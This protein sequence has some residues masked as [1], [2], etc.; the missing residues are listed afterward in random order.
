MFLDASCLYWLCNSITR[1]A[2]PNIIIFSVWTIAVQYFLQGVFVIVNRDNQFP[3]L[4]E[5][6]FPSWQC[7]QLRVVLNLPLP[8][9]IQNLCNSCWTCISSVVR[10]S[11]FVNCVFIVSTS[12][13]RNSWTSSVSSCSIYVQVLVVVHHFEKLMISWNLRCSKDTKGFWKLWH[14]EVNVSMKGCGSTIG[15]CCVF[16]TM[17]LITV[18]KEK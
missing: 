11:E 13:R 7:A 12:L 6:Y 1:A 2:S 18:A 8:N 10:L 14:A 17:E 16:M 15:F 3:K 9:L 5:F 4:W